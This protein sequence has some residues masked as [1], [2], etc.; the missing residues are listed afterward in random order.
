MKKAHVLPDGSA[1]FKTRIG[2]KK[3]PNGKFQFKALSRAILD[4]RVKEDLS[5]RAAAK[6]AGIDPGTFN[7]IE[8]GKPCK[9]DNLAKVCNW[10]G[11]QV[12]T[13]F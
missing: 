4:K 9:L 12:Q 13:F 10:L 6:Q 3:Q 8:F 11:V 1:F 2:T 5:T 7:N